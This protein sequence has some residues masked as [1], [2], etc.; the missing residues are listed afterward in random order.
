[1]MGM[2]G[3]QRRTCHSAPATDS[4]PAI[5]PPQPLQPTARL[6][7]A[8]ACPLQLG[9]FL[10]GLVQRAVDVLELF[11]QLDAN[12]QAVSS[13]EMAVGVAAGTLSCGWSASH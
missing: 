8:A 4:S 10:E 11:F 12:E 7:L 3:E 2:P 9:D 1:M 6:P 13:A 5:V